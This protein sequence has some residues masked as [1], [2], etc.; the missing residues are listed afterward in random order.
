MTIPLSEMIRWLG[1]FAPLELAEPW[2][3]VGLLLGDPD[4]PVRKVMTCLTVTGATAAEA[5][6]SGVDLIVSHHPIL[7]RPVQKIVGGN[8][9]TA[10]VWALA[11]AGIAVYSPH[12]A[13]DNAISGIN[14]GLAR[15]LALVDLK[16]MRPGAPLPHSKIVAFTP[17]ADRGPVLAAAF[18]AGAG[19]IGNYAECSFGAKGQGTFHGDENSSPKVGQAGTR[20]TVDEWR[21]EF[22]CPA[23]RVEAVVGAIRVAHSY[24]E[25]AIDVFPL[26]GGPSGPGSGRIGTLPDAISLGELAD[27]VAGLLPTPAVQIVGDRDRTVRRVAICCGAGDDFVP[28]AAGQ[29][30][31]VLLTGE[32]RFH[33]C[34]EAEALG[35]GL[36]LPGHH[37][38]ERPGVEDLAVA[39]EMAF[40]SLD[41][42][43]SRRETDPVRC[44]S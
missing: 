7:F 40:T 3:N 15:R 39:L 2:D 26:A 18:A 22:V 30:A 9:E 11:R 28:D 38:T 43:A 35:L 24:E 4:Q 13:F 37:A 33:R 21:L 27:R 14:A 23:C 29:G 19:R 17:E 16:P 32:A 8:H 41:V 34:L 25:P 6:Q 20:E 42:W 31:D 12:T 36:V 1:E 44:P 10:E 5:I